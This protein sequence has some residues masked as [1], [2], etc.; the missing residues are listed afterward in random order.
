MPPGRSPARR[1]RSASPVLVRPAW[2]P[3][4]VLHP[5]RLLQTLL[6]ELVKN[7]WD[8]I[9]ESKSNLNSIFAKWS[10]EVC[11]KDS[12]VL[13][14]MFLKL[15]KY[16]SQLEDM[17]AQKTEQL[18]EEQRRTDL[19]LNSILPRPVIESLKAGQPVEPEKFDSV[20]VYFSDIVGF[21]T[22]S[23]FSRPIEIVTLLNELYTVFDNTI[24]NYD[25]Y[26]VET[27]G[28]A[29]MVAGGVPQRSPE[30]A[31]QVALMALDLVYACNNFKIPHMVHVPLH[32]RIG[33]H[34]GPVVAGVVGITMPRYCLFGDTVNIASRL[35]STGA[36]SC[37][38]VHGWLSGWHSAAQ[39]CVSTSVRPRR[40]SWRTLAASPPSTAGKSLS[41]S[42]FDSKG[43]SQEHISSPRSAE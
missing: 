19:V 29:Y 14:N 27:I 5:Q 8:S 4:L 1:P 32:L 28:D 11:R 17:V 31:Q 38:S 16:S 6:P 40:S 34:S 25:V 12:S 9:Y 10:D 35:E 18:E 37:L 30:H 24:A 42:S 3:S 21:T 43:N 39:G 36:G 23:A 15:D 7:K 20:S 2:R 41:R 13:D 22:I 26:K 33:I